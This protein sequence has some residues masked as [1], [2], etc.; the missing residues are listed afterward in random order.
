MKKNINNQATATKPHTGSQNR[1]EQP[2]PAPQRTARQ[3]T[4]SKDPDG[5][6]DGQDRPALG[7]IDY[8]QRFLNRALPTDKLLDLLKIEAPD[9]FPQAEIIGKWVWITFP[10]K[11]P[12]EV[13]AQLAQ[14]GFHWNNKRQSWQHPCGAPRKRPSSQDPRERYGSN[15]AAA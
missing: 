10:D 2:K 15:K 9:L 8:T 4:R 14:L 7:G 12:R 13:T 3:S 11:Q 6:D 5:Q 1:T